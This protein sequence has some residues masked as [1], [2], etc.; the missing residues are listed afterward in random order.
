VPADDGNQ[1]TLDVCS[2]GSPAHPASASG[3]ACNQSGGAKCDG[4]GACVAC[5]AASDCPGVDTDCAKRACNAGTCVVENAPVGT[6]AATQ[7]AG[8]CRAN[9]CDGAGNVANVVEDSDIPV[10][11]NP[12]TDDVCTG[13]VGS[14][15]G[16]VAGVPCG[17]GNLCDGTGVCV[18]CLS[19]SDCPGADSECAVRTCTSGACGMLFAPADTLVSGQTAGDCR[20]NRCDGAGNVASFADDADVPNDGN[21]CTNDVCTGG[22]PSSTSAPAFTACS[23]RSGG[24]TCDGSGKCVTAFMVARFGDGVGSLSSAAAPVFLD[25]FTTAGSLLRTIALPTTAR[26]A[27]RRFANSGS[28]TSEGALALS[29]DGH[30]VTLAGYDAAPGLAS[31]ASTAATANP[32][33]VAR[34][35]AAGN[36]DTSVSLGAAF[37]KNN[38]RGA[39]TDDGKRFWV[40]GANGGSTGGIQFVTIDGS[41][42]Q[43]A[44]LSNLSN[45]RTVAIFGPESKRQLYGSAS[46]GAF[47]NVFSV[48]D[49]LPA[50]SAAAAPL[51]GMPASGASPFAFVFAGPSTLYV[52]DDRAPPAGGVQKWTLSGSTWVLSATFTAGTVG[53]RG[54]TGYAVDGGFVLLATTAEA[55]GQHVVMFVDTGAGSPAAA[56]LVNA[57]ANEVFRGIALPPF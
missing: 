23:D 33:V 10:D 57:P 20:S 49:G 54:L 2:S 32:R 30:F 14:N 45:V 31:V 8:D 36:V 34:V 13:G 48:G 53:A 5:L 37:D 16:T 22:V 21:A 27:Q 11:G 51:P 26:G 24:N 55:S 19:A 15:P 3:L 9:R 38:V 50:S 29:S 18:G 12:C 41:A 44:L 6:P 47:N 7:V 52:A 35:D 1:C 40:S 17:N 4:Q 46:S 56:T 39:V 25:E 28:A 42:P 43:L